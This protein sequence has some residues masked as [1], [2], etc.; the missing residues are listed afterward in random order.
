MAARKLA[1]AAEL[2][3]R[4]PEPGC[5][6][7]GP[8][9]MPAACGEFTAE[10]LACALAEHRGRAEDLLTIAAALESRLPGTRAA[11]RDGIVRL[12]KAWII[13]CA[14]A[15]LDPE[16][17]RQAEA[18]VLGRA[19]RLT[20]GGLR[21][22]IARAVIDVA[23]DKA[24]KRREEAA[25]DARVQQWA[26]DSG[27]AALMGR[28]L[29]RPRSSPRTSGSPR[30]P[31]SSGQP[32]SRAT[33]T[34]C[35]PAPIWI[36]CWVRTPGPARTPRASRTAQAGRTAA[37]QAVLEAAARTA[38][39]QAVL[40]AAARTAAGQAVL[41]AA[42]RTAAAWRRRPG[43]G[44]GSCPGPAGPGNPAAGPPASAVPTGLAG[45][46]TLTI[47]L[48][49]L[50]GLAD[51]PAEIG[52]IGPIDPALARDLANSAAASPRTTWCVTVTDQDGHAIGHG[53]ARPEPRSHARRRD[54]QGKPSPPGGLIRPAGPATPRG[55]DSP[56]R[57]QAST[58]R[59]ADTAPGGCGSGEMSRTRSSRSTRSPPKAATTALRPGPR[60]R[61]QAAAPV[62]GPARHLHRT[63]LPKTGR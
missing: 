38:A 25:R 54:K 52:G 5:P 35:A 51:R 2:I 24:R 50:L 33:W 45:R 6:L 40:E 53:C 61:G 59:Q 4:R 17:A 56:S 49:T 8:A 62:P 58:V 26:E 15:L 37:G 55:Q 44:G 20:P 63:G 29:P 13:A 19:G 21:A 34:C 7:E 42:A 41:E 47:P 11:L 46:I 3:R 16:E 12:D 48:A 31:G 36:C 30:G 43:G 22:A 32:G 60:P 39:G 27:N 18:M 9:Q 57:P 1:A 10:E 28:E 14:T 23:P